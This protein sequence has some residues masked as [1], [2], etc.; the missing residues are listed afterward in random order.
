MTPGREEARR[1][2]TV[3]LHTL[4]LLVGVC[5]SSNILNLANYIFAFRNAMPQAA[6]R[7]A[8]TRSAA[9][10]LPRE[11][12]RLI[13][14]Q[15]YCDGVDELAVSHVRL[16]RW[17][18][19]LIVLPATANM[20]GQAAHGLASGLLSSTI[21]AYPKPVMFFPSMNRVMWERPSTCRNV[22]R[23]R[24]DGHT[25]VEPEPGLAWIVGSRELQLSLG[26]PQPALVAEEVR[27]RLVR[28]KL[29]PLQEAA[30]SR[31]RGEEQERCELSED[32]DADELRA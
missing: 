31:R 27:S 26:L 24:S 21:L 1:S 3:G 32:Q 4:N 29:E 12:L 9:A 25:V 13:C 28:P 16:A 17:A 14:D 18:D 6:I 11:T 30:A 5:G 7:A 22:D 20:L 2:G 10:L 23:L 8:M 19:E 15:V